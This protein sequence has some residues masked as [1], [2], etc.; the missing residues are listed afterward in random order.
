ASRAASSRELSGEDMKIPKMIFVLALLF[1]LVA[2]AAP[3]TPTLPPTKPLAIP[4]T[5]P[6][7]SGVTSCPATYAVPGNDFRSDDPKKLDQ[8]GKPKLVEFYAVW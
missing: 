7:A 6:A 2:C 5:V 1:T 4:P 8:A 3:A